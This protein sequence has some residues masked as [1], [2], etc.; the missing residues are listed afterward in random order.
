DIVWWASVGKA[1]AS[2]VESE[3]KV[4]VKEGEEGGHFEADEKITCDWDGKNIG[5]L[6]IGR[7]IEKPKITKRTRKK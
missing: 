3:G 7:R 2:K 1:F 5:K 4:L 6:C